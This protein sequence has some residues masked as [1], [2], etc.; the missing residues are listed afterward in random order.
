MKRDGEKGGYRDGEGM[1][2]EMK[3]GMETRIKRDGDRD[4]EG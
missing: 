2:T 4:E 3:T 1:E